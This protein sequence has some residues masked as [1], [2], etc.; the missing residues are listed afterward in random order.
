MHAKIEISICL[1]ALKNKNGKK[2]NNSN[3]MS[4]DIIENR[5]FLFLPTNTRNFILSYNNP[6]K[7]AKHVVTQKHKLRKTVL[8]N[9]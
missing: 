7:C 2:Q 6:F 9:F 1:S 8:I 4:M 5:P 3:Q